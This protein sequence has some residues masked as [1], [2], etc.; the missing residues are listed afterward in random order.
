MQC[1]TFIDLHVVGDII[2]AGIILLISLED[3]LVLF[4]MT[5][6]LAEYI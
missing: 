1:I 6:A 3:I 2:R 5:R 4:T